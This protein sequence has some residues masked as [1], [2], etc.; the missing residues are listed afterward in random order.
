MVW[1]CN[2]VSGSAQIVIATRDLNAMQTARHSERERVLFGDHDDRRPTRRYLRRIG[3]GCLASLRRCALL[4]R[5]HG[6][7]VNLRD[8]VELRLTLR[9]LQDLCGNDLGLSPEI[10]DRHWYVL[11]LIDLFESYRVLG[12]RIGHNQFYSL[13]AKSPLWFEFNEFTA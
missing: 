6:R 10:R 9:R 5:L 1:A 8:T 2:A 13:H 12:L 11:F 4:K 7:K 3:Q